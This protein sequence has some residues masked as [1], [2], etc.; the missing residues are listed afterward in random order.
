MLLHIFLQKSFNTRFS[1]KIFILKITFFFM[2]FH[3]TIKNFILRC[4]DFLEHTSSKCAVMHSCEHCS[5]LQKKCRVNNEINHCIKCVHLNCKCNLTFL[6]MKWKRIKIKCNHVLNELL[7]AH[8][9]MQEIF[10]RTTHLQNQFMFL[11]NK[12]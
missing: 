3:H 7:N 1:F 12:K 10:I 5:C 11:K 4:K 8:K 6:M 9:Q 2:S